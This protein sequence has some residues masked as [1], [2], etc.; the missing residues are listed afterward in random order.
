[1]GFY[2]LF[3]RLDDIVMELHAQQ[4]DYTEWLKLEEKILCERMKTPF[5]A[6]RAHRLG[7]ILS[8]RG[9]SCMQRE[10]DDAML[11]CQ[12]A[13]D[14]QMFAHNLLVDIGVSLQQLKNVENQVEK[15]NDRMS[16]AKVLPCKLFKF[17][18]SSKY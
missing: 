14:N 2:M 13:N 1:M 7:P 6:F 15:I 17:L 18:S 10:G 9:Q 3:R 4:K 16:T 11:S 5:A 12:V 8:N